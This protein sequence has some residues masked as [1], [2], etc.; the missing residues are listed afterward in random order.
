MRDNLP[1]TVE[2]C[3]IVYRNADIAALE[4]YDCGKALKALEIEFGADLLRRS[5]V[6]LTAKESRVSFAIEH[7]EQQRDRIQRFAVV[8]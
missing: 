6:W 3:P 2:F 1:G 8:M 5:A 7:E 4:Q